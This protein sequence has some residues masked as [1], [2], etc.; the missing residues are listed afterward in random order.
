[1]E[2]ETKPKRNEGKSWLKIYRRMMAR[3]LSQS[4]P[5]KISNVI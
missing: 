3:K 5:K 1:M 2:K 4:L